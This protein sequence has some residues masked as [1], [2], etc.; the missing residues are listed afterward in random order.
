M[1]LSTR[2]HS[3]EQKRKAGRGPFR[4]SPVAILRER[5]RRHLLEQGTEEP[6]PAPPMVHGKY[7]SIAE[8]LRSRYDLRGAEQ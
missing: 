3:L 8:V 1:K 4:P 6:T 5:R 7:H 2:I